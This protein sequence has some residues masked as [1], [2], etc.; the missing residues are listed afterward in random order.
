MLTIFDKVE[1]ELT[2][3]ERDHIFSI[4]AGIIK[5]KPLDLALEENLLSVNHWDTWRLRH[6]K[7]FVIE[8]GHV[9]GWEDKAKVWHK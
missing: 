5:L 2:K 6:N 9:T 4:L 1:R 7:A 3:G 8:D